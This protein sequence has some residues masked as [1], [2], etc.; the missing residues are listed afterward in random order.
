MNGLEHGIIPANIRARGN[1]QAAHQAC[2]QVAS[3]VAIQIREHHYVELRRIHNHIHAERIHNTLI[4][5]NIRVFSSHFARR[6]QKQTIGKLHDIRFMDSGNFLSSLLFRVIERVLH[7]VARSC[8]GNRLQRNTRI[9]KN[10]ATRTLLHEINERGGFCGA[11]L[12]LN[13]R[14]Q[15][16]RVFTHNNQVNVVVAPTCTGKRHNGTQTHIQLERLTQCDVHAAKASTHRR[17]NRAFDSH[18]IAT[19]GL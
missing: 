14:V 15:I 3:N 8:F 18:A 13:A 19:N 4:E 6:M 5:R 10:R 16:F 11:F 1:A 12:K 7:N 17:G 2:C 9:G